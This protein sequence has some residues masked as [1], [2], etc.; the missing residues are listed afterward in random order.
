MFCG[1]VVNSRE[2]A[3]P[4]WILEIN[5][6]E[7]P[8]GGYRGGVTPTFIHG[9]NATL[10]VRHVC[11][12]KCNNGWMS[13]LENNA[14]AVFTPLI[15]DVP[16]DLNPVRQAITAV[17]TVKTAMVFEFLTPKGTPHFYTD[18]ERK[19]LMEKRA[20]PDD[21]IVW[22]GRYD[23]LYSPTTAGVEIGDT[24]NP[25]GAAVGLYK[26]ITIGRLALQ[27]LTLRREDDRP[28]RLRTNPGAWSASLFQIWPTMS[29]VHWPPPLSFSDHGNRTLRSLYERFWV[30]APDHPI[31]RSIV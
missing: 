16:T 26:T 1:G 12:F 11:K 25:K 18:N 4:K 17:W 19:A 6:K 3:W 14:K 21:T 24:K 23:G 13:V 27:V 10:K 29:S 2:D 31:W 30:G 7:H 8:I 15:V 22:I 28:I 20:I 9:P 5:N